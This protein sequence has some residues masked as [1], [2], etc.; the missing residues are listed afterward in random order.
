MTT[1]GHIH[2]S[3]KRGVYVGRP[4]KWG[5]P[6]HI[7]QHGTREQVIARY[8]AWLL[9]QPELCAA[10]RRE[11]R[12]KHLLCWCHPLACHADVLAEVAESEP[13]QE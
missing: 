2:H 6:F 10:A 3:S 8:R 4:T 11:L 7:G 9:A 13:S 1:V 12:G 5:N